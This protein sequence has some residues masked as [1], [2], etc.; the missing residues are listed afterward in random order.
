MLNE[1][2]IEG[3]IT[4]DVEL[5]TTESGVSVCSFSIAHRRDYKIGDEYPTDFFDVVAWRKKAELVCKHFKKGDLIKIVGSFETRKYTDKNGNN[6]VAYELK[7]DK[8]Y[9]GERR[10]QSDAAPAEEAPH[11][12]NN[13]GGSNFDPNFTPMSDDDDLPF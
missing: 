8:L 9:F 11:F 12:G 13:Q 6:R 2:V 1:T 5:K 4:Q 10:S 3:R 7:A